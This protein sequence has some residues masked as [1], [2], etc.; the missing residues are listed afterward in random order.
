MICLHCL[1]I[2]HQNSLS[3]HSLNFGVITLIPKKDNA[4]KIQEYRPI[5]FLNVSFKIITK[6]LSNRIGLVADRIVRP[7]QTAFMRGRNILEGVII[8]HESIH[9]LQRKKLDEI[10]LMLDFEKAYD[11]VN[12]KFL[13]QAMHIKGFSPSWCAWIHTI[14]SAFRDRGV[15]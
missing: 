3:D 10:I 14:V 2:F 12:W 6:V 4:I 15:P 13:Q 7:S 8:L 5:C 9:E 1:W 11:K